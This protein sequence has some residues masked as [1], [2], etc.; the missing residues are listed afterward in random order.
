MT[1]SRFLVEGRYTAGLK[2]FNKIN[3]NPGGTTNKNRV[4]SVLVGVHF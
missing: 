3:Q 4:F 1:L 2:D